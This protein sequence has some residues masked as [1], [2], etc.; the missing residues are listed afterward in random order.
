M[1][2]RALPHCQKGGRPR[3]TD[4]RDAV[5]LARLMR[6]GDLTPVYVPAVEDEAIRDL[7][8]ARKMPSA[9]SRPPSSISKP[10]CSATI[11]AITAGHL[12]PGP[13]A[14]ALRSGLCHPHSTDVF[15]EYVRAVH[16]HTER[17]ERLHQELQEQLKSWRLQRVVE[18]LEGLRG[19]RSTWP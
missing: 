15:Q 10:L 9:I 16:G 11:S 6:S 2:R 17:L 1:G 4:R 19:V 18:A 13:S 3:E 12:E 8:Q 7:G 14:V 5:Q